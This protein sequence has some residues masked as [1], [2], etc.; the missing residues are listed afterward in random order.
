MTWRLARSLIVLRDE[1]NERWPNRSRIS[2]GTI[3]DQAHSSRKSSHN[4]DRHGV[5]RGMDITAKGIEADWYAEHLR[6]MGQHGDQRVLYVI[7]KRRIC[8]D[9]QGWVWRP[10]SGSNPHD[11]HIHLSVSDDPRVYDATGPWGIRDP[12][13]PPAKP[14]TPIVTEY[15]EDAMKRIDIKVSLDADGNGYFD[16]R[17]INAADVLSLLSNAADPQAVKGY[18][19]DGVVLQRCAVGGNV[20]RIVALDGPKK[21]VIDVSVWL[22]GG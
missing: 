22:A 1:L 12:L 11:K 4:P 13:E 19:T 18:P 7:W 15:P 5:A 16:L 6:T 14:F 17:D 21:G 10:Y 2:D 20:T 3:G 9:K 8:S